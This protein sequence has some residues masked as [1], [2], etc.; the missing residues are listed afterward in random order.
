MLAGVFGGCGR[1]SWGRQEFSSAPSA[2]KVIFAG[3]PGAPDKVRIVSVL[4]AGANMWAGSWILRSSQLPCRRMKWCPPPPGERM[5][6]CRVCHSPL[7]LVWESFGEASVCCRD[8]SGVGV[9]GV[10]VA[11]THHMFHQQLQH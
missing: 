8:G 6:Q 1:G 2:G 3:A 7:I 11:V 5:S 10:Y 9:R 4:D